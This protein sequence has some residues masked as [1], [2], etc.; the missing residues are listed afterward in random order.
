MNLLRSLALVGLAAASAQAQVAFTGSYS[1]NFDSLGT[2]RIDL[3]DTNATAHSIG[4][5]GWSAARSSLVTDFGVDVWA[6]SNSNTAGLYNFGN[7]G[8]PADRS[9]GSISY[10]VVYAF[11][12]R[13]TN[14]TGAEIDSLTISFD[15]EFWRTTPSTTQ[16]LNF[17]YGFLG[18]TVTATNFL[19]SGAPTAVSQ[20][21]VTAP[22]SGT[23]VILDGNLPA[24]RAS[25]SYTLTNLNWAPSQ[26]LFLRWQDADV[27]GHEAGIAIDNLSV[28]SI[29]EPSAAAAL[30]GAV[31]LGLV[32]L[33]RRRR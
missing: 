31:V 6:F 7:A 20:L 33:R 17:A 24:N 21:S 2:S 4:L 14:S 3:P 12:A 15:A 26:T 32:A 28:S 16:T 27:S 25:I 22:V 29:P 5:A 18:G 13:F 10:S 30:A 9:L 23:N 11:G 1:Q 8:T 19:S